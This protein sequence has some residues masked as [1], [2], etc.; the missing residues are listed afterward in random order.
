MLG[1]KLLGL[2]L[3]GSLA[4]GGFQRDVSDVDL[5]AAT[6]TQLDD[7][8]FDN[9]RAMH[10]EVAR[11]SGDW[12]HRIDVAYV[13][14]AALRGCLRDYRYPAIFG[15]DPLHWEESVSDLVLTRHVLWKSGI[16]LFGPAPSTIVT[17][18]P[19]DD[20]VRVV[21]E[22]CTG[23]WRGFIEDIRTCKEQAFWTLLMCR[24]LF[25]VREGEVISKPAAALWAQEVLPEWSST[26]RRAL[27]W[28]QDAVAMSDG[29]ANCE[30]TLPETRRFVS[31]A[32]EQVLGGV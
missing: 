1:Q 22:A 20:L 10:E 16:A 9:L 14:T 28:W 21:R 30:A 13:S 12:G 27:G 2:Y 18:V 24:A 5:V 3:S 29:L 15:H 25:T 19:R 31:F 32:V 6:S 26:I 8:E 11:S 23:E 7:R 17:P 4:T